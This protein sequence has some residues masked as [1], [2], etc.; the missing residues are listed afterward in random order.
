MTTQE[1]RNPKASVGRRRVSGK[2]P[3]RETHAGA[4]ARLGGPDHRVSASGRHVKRASLK[5]KP[6]REQTGQSKKAACLAMLER[7]DG[8]SLLELMLA[9]GWQKHSVRGFLSGQVRKRMD[10]SLIS[11]VTEAGERRYWISG[12]DRK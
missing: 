1:K 4:D 3:A 6:G 9:T 2:R 12:G 11:A 10:L 5:K 8:A 7:A